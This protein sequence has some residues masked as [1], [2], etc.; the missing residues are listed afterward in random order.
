MFESNE[1]REVEGVELG[2]AIGKAGNVV[3][4]SE[5]DVGVLGG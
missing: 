1:F 5:I 2:D 4:G 3:F